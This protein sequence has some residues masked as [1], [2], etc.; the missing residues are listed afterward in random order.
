MRK[1]NVEVVE[2]LSR[3]VETEAKDYNEAV[4]N[5]AD[6]YHNEDIVLDYNDLE[7]TDYKA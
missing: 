6:K 1:F 2:T 7:K 5:V 3:V 4:L